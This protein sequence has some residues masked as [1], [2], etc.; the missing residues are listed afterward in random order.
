MGAHDSLMDNAGSSAR[1]SGVHD[2][3][4]AETSTIRQAG[5]DQV[6][7]INGQWPPMD[8][9]LT[10][11]LS[12]ARWRFALWHVTEWLEKYADEDELETG[13]LQLTSPHGDVMAT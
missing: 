11:R 8:Q 6:P 3:T 2:G 10:I 4:S 13:V 1:Q 12:G 9:V 5:W 7:W